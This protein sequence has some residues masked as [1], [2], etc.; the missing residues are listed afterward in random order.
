VVIRMIVV[1]TMV[2]TTRAHS[3][4]LSSRDVGLEWMGIRKR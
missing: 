3:L 1:R 4:E 2:C